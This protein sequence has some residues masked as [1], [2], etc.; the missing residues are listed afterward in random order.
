MRSAMIE[1]VTVR[2][3]VADVV[4]MHALNQARCRANQAFDY[5]VATGTFGAKLAALMLWLASVLLDRETFVLSRRANERHQAPSLQRVREALRL[6][7]IR[8]L[9]GAA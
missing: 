7:P 5:A 3:S 4:P 6:R 9:R 2:E 8:N 1:V